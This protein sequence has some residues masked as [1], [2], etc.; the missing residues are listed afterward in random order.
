M[1]NLVFLKKLRQSYIWKRIFY[2]RLTEP[3]HLNIISIFVALF[4]SLRAKISFDLIIRHHHAYALLQAAD[5]AKARGISSVTAI[6]FGVAAGAGLLNL[7]SLAKRVTAETGV[8]FEIFGFDTG[9]GMPPPQSYKDHP[10][11]YQTGEYQMDHA[12]L[13]KKLD[14]NTTLVLG[15]IGTT[16]E[17]FLKKDF[18]T[19]PIGFVS[20]DVDY[21]SS[22]VDVLQVFKTS[23]VN[24]LPRVVV[25]LDD[26]QDNSHNS[27]CGE[28]A[29]IAEFSAETPL[30]PIEKHPFF[31]GYRIFKNARWID[32]IYQCHVLDHPWRSSLEK[33]RQAITL[34]NPYL[35]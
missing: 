26:L 3:L 15:P 21:Y 1:S 5:I 30:R 32:H 11:L 8:K 10:D 31:R 29:A 20:I 24:L 9:E 6:E 35:E 27:R 34:P 25:Y 14:E 17:T 28:Q 7:Q 12:L 13:A 19:S 2:E 18:S 33:R 4:G 22:T 16:V 23:P